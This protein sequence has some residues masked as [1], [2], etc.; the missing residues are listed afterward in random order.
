MGASDGLAE[1]DRAGGLAKRRPTVSGQAFGG[2]SSQHR[3]DVPCSLNGDN[4]CGD[5]VPCEDAD[6]KEEP[7]IS[8]HEAG[9]LCEWA[10]EPRIMA[11]AVAM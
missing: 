3:A 7:E 4:D 11:M 10:S 6:D 5:G 1:G 2:E 8:H 9:L